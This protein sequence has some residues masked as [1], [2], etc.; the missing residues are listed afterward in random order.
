VY[1]SV[2]LSFIALLLSLIITPA[3]R[4]FAVRCRIVDQ[5]DG[6]RKMHPQ[7][8]ARF[9]GVAVATSYVAA[10]GIFLLTPT[11][12][13]AIVR[14]NTDLIW[15][16]LP[17]AALIFITGVVDDLIGL[18]PLHKLGAQV[19]AASLAYMLGVRILGTVFDSGHAWW[20]LPITVL[21]LVLTTNAFNL[22]DG[23]DGLAAGLGFF[24][25]ITAFV[26]AVLNQNVPLALATG[27]L[28]G[29]LL[30]FLRYNFNPAS[31]FLG[32]SGSLLI[33]FLLGC[34]SVIWSHKSATLI[35][36]IAPLMA[37]AI[38]LL[39]TVLAVSRRFLRNR[40]IFTAD[41]GHLHHLLL[42]R[43]LTPR[44]VVL[45]L[46]G[47][48]AVG[49]IFSVLQD[50]VEMQYS[51]LIVPAFVGFTLYGVRLLR[52]TELDVAS[53]MLFEGSV[54]RMFDAQ[55]ALQAIESSL[56]SAQTVSDC[57][58]TIQSGARE[59]GFSHIKVCLRG[60]LWEKTFSEVRVRES[61]IVRVSLAGRDYVEFQHNNHY[62]G[63]DM[64]GPFV[65]VVCRQLAM[66]HVLFEPQ[67][68]AFVAHAQG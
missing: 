48:A 11:A 15:S 35:G 26:S 39:D 2:F 51:A 46:Y 53:R 67:E 41:R 45:L 38:P 7:A 59:F 28:A 33:G 20:S 19:A 24:A 63:P 29:C 57:W 56:R 61:W 16:I 66:K 58:E 5:P 22:I 55:L 43:G 49:A 12:A 44:R 1:S 10:F 36:M 40:P 17:A 32:D 68:A 47:L 65:D 54:R 4:W 31:I 37:V 34:Y 50:V 9:G 25:S 18:K 64:I 8:I 21:W 14:E 27:P 30:G 62:L 23:L 42:D 6:N 52:V 60:R 3:V 13:S